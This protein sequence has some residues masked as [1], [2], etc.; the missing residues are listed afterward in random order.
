MWKLKKRQTEVLCRRDADSTDIEKLMVSGGDSLGGGGMCLGYGMEILW[1][2]IVMF[3]IQL[4]M[5]QIH[6]SNNKIK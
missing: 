1:N 5:W 3:I 6:L 2:Q 4:Q